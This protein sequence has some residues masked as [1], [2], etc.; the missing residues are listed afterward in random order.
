MIKST[1]FKAN[2]VALEVLLAK[3]NRETV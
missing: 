1:G 3:G 2:I